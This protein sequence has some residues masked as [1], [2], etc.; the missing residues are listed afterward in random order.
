VLSEKDGAMKKMMT[1]I[2]FGVGSPLGT[3]SQY[4]SWIH[5]DDLCSMF[6]K[7]VEDDSMRGVYNATGP[8]AATNAELTIAIARVLR[9]PLWLP[10]V[11]TFV[12]KIVLGEMADIVLQGSKVSSRKIQQAGFQFQFPDLQQALENLLKKE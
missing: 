1:P 10:A 5:I 11:P 9:K 8:N 2:Q 3:G 12:L 6:M 4:V 7:A